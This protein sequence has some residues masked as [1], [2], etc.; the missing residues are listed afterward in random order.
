[1]HLAADVRRQLASRMMLSLLRA[2][3]GELRQRVVLLDEF[4]I[5]GP[6]I[7]VF[8]SKKRLLCGVARMN[9][10]GACKDGSK[11]GQLSV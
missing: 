4:D 2:V 11:S 8:P 5:I 3:G 10:S 1:M 6:A 7:G 9:T